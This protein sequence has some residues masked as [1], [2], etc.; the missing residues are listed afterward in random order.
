MWK[1]AGWTLSQYFIGFWDSNLFQGLSCL[2]NG[3]CWP[4]LHFSVQTGPREEMFGGTSEEEAQASVYSCYSQLNLGCD[5]FSL[6]AEIICNSLQIQPGFCEHRNVWE[7]LGPW[8]GDAGEALV[9]AGGAG[10]CKKGHLSSCSILSAQ[11]VLREEMSTDNIPGGEPR[12][13]FWG[14]MMSGCGGNSPF[15]TPTVPTRWTGCASQGQK[16]I[17]LNLLKLSLS[18]MGL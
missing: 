10:P 8:Q 15:P 3:L 18:L 2:R 13:V 9:P 5:C 16:P 14:S 7:W 12:E 1:D 6:V 11:R 4:R 17:L